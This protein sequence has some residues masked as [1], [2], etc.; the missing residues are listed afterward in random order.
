MAV[1]C[2]PSHVVSHHGQTDRKMTIVCANCGGVGHIYK[3]CNHPVTSYGIIC[4]RVVFDEKQNA[5]Y[6]EYL[7]VQRKDSLSYV[8]FLRGKYSIDNKAY[9]MNLFSNMTPTERYKLATMDFDS[10]WKDLWQIH[11]CNAF[12][13]D[14]VNSRVKF[15]FLK[16]GYLLQNE[17]TTQ[18]YYFSIDYIL[19]NTEC[20]LQEC[21]WGFPKGRRNINEQDFTC[22]LR[23]FREET[24]INTRYIQILKDQKPFEE[25][26]SG[27]N[28]VRYKHIYYLAMSTDDRSFTN[29]MPSKSFGKEIQ[30]IQ[31]LRYD[32]AQQKIREHNIERK[33]LFK[34]VNQVIVKNMYQIIHQAA[35]MMLT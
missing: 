33:E 15:N 22:A 7:M 25:V 21:E 9:L 5:L 13:K 3:N 28:K 32:D 24:G 20:V 29:P 10:L 4:F 19:R 18:T 11:E 35:S 14:Y 30:S 23:E 8:E 17:Q 2:Y 1:T 34:R 26:F 16:R 31:W 27:S 12:Q 6:P